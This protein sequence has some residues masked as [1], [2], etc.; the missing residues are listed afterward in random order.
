MVEC[1][2]KKLLAFLKGGSHFLALELPFYGDRQL[3]LIMNE[4]QIKAT[5]FFFDGGSDEGSLKVL[6]VI[7]EGP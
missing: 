2:E 4:L 5:I 6:G 3:S 7:K 1:K